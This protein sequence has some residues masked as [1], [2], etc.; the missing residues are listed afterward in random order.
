M[1]VCGPG[2]IA[3]QPASAPSEN[4]RDWQRR[5]V[6]RTVDVEEGGFSILMPEQPQLRRRTVT[7][8]TSPIPAERSSRKSRRRRSKSSQTSREITQYLTAVQRSY[9]ALYM[10]GW[11]ES[12]DDAV[13]RRR[14]KRRRSKTQQ[15]PIDRQ[16]VQQQLEAEREHLLTRFGGRLLAEEPVYLNAHPG[17]HYQLLS[18]IGSER[19]VITNRAYW[20]GDR[21]YQMTVAVPQHR[22]PG[23]V[24]MAEGFMRS[25]QVN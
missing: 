12:R 25:F 5:T 1:A 20:V 8:S 4:L 18:Q 22:F 16:Q 17:Q 13:G 15:K 6:W 9:G 21:L 19:Y 23:F 2:A 24:G 7:E 11:S 3:A 10:V 14:R